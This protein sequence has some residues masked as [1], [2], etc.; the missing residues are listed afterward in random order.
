MFRIKILINSL[1]AFAIIALNNVG[2]FA[3]NDFSPEDLAGVDPDFMTDENGNEVNEISDL[4]G[5]GFYF[6]KVRD[7]HPVAYNR[8]LRMKKRAYVRR[9]HKNQYLKHSI[10]P[11]QR[12]LF[13]KRNEL[14]KQMQT[15]MKNGT[16]RFSDRVLYY[17]DRNI[18]S[19]SGIH[20][21][22]KSSDTYDVPG[23]TNLLQHGEVPANLA[24]AV[25]Y[26]RIL[27]GYKP[28]QGSTENQDFPS[29]GGGFHNN[30]HNY[31]DLEIYE[32]KKVIF[33][34]PMS[35]MV[36]SRIVKGSNTTLTDRGLHGYNLK[37]P[38]LIR[39]GKKLQF[40]IKV[41]D[42]YQIHVPTRTIFFRVE[43]YGDGTSNK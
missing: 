24:M 22:I 5:L 39:P 11:G 17:T 9:N 34:I 23:L 12:Y 4:E 31:C 26:I 2:V 6:K 35:A 37:Q 15:D 14:P 42:G 7:R 19:I 3:Y 27:V 21:L 20:E 10:T 36:E 41:A 33:S 32:D 18:A 30:S 16:V 40:A 43:L 1:I 38:L 28:V 13:G 29:L 8:F 25:D